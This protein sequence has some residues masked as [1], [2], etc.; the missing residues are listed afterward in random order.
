MLELYFFV[1]PG[2][3]LGKLLVD[4]IGFG[5]SDANL[6]ML[7]EGAIFYHGKADLDFHRGHS[8]P[9]RHELDH[10][11]RDFRLDAEENR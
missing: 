2:S 6:E 11:P 1:E 7:A 5:I 9:S 10:T 4:L 8:G 3:T